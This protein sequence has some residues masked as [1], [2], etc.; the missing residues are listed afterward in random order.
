MQFTQHT[1]FKVNPI[2]LNYGWKP[3]NKL[4]SIIE[5]K[6]TVFSDWTT[7]NVS[8]LMKQIPIYVA[9]NEKGE[10]KNHMV[11]ARERRA[12]CFSSNKSLKRKPV[13]PVSENVQYLCTFL[14]KSGQ[15]SHWKR[16]IRKN[17][18]LPL[19]VSNT[20]SIQ[21]TIKI[22]T[23]NYYHHSF[24]FRHHWRMICHRTNINW[25]GPAENT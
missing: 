4:T 21:Q 18:K 20:R 1:G 9:R 13:K 8:V 7:L 24:I 12:P 2:E 22:S 17:E 11:M 19:T 15:K 10:V 3:W 6:K 23:A 14:E 5:G 16:T 25:A